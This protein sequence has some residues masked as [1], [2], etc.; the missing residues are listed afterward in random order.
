MSTTGNLTVKE[1][2]SKIKKEEAGRYADGGGLYF[3]VPK[4]G[5][6]YWMVRYTSNKKRKEMTLGKYSD[7]SLKDAR[8]EAASKMKQLR[9]GL[10]PLLAKKGNDAS[11][12]P[13]HARAM[14]WLAGT[15]QRLKRVF[16]I[17]ITECEKCQQHNVSVIACIIDSH[18]IQKILEHLD[19]KYP[20]SS[21]T[22]LLPPLRAPPDEQRDFNFGA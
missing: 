18:V 3:V 1:V 21:Q 15:A 13:Y 16:N 19:K 6:A 4:S 12:K 11:E 20:T 17:D 14:S 9:E 5:S 10:D 2:E 8:Y 22:T 7:L